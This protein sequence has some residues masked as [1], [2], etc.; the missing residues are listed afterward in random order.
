MRCRGAAQHDAAPDASARSRVPPCQ[1][2]RQDVGGER[3]PRRH[4]VTWRVGSWTGAAKVSVVLGVTLLGACAGLLAFSLSLTHAEI[5]EN[6]YDAYVEARESL[7]RGWLPSVLPRSA[8]AIHEWHD[9][10]THLCVGSF[11]FDSGER[12][13]IES[14]LRPGLRSRIRID[15]DPSFASPVR[16]D[17]SEEQLEN[18][19]FGFYS[20]GAFGFAIHWDDGIAYF[21]SSSS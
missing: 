2:V 13:A 21:W 11:R 9:P 7:D 3:G 18:L 1:R 5:Q 19:G 16:F 15:R 17:P 4:A 12:V 10:E 6:R 14:R 8:T 20:D